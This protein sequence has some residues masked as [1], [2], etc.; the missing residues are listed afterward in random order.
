MSADGQ[1]ARASQLP[2]PIRFVWRALRNV[3]AFLPVTRPFAFPA[4]A[5]AE[6]FGPGD[7]SYAW[8]VFLQHQA[9]LLTAGYKGANSIFEMGP[10]RNIA[11]GLLW[12]AV[13]T[14]HG[15]GLRV[16]LWDVFKNAR[17]DSDTWRRCASQLLNAMP[18]TCGGQGGQQ[19]CAVLEQVAAG[20]VIPD[21]AYTVVP[22][23]ELD[24]VCGKQSFELV[25]SH[26]A[27][28]ANIRTGGAGSNGSQWLAFTPNR[29]G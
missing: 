11:T 17:V 24:R 10:G 5:L 28:D 23:A 9:R 26:A 4:G 2:K 6:S 19:L 14:W 20:S 1:V 18:D 16:V 15:G 29:F 3:L 12:W 7:A 27:I 13:E 22:L 25:Y 21:I 8:K